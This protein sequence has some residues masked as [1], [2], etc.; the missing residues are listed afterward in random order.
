MVIAQHLL[1]GDFKIFEWI[2]LKCYHNDCMLE[3]DNYEIMITDEASFPCKIKSLVNDQLLTCCKD[4]FSLFQGVKNLKFNQY[5]CMLT[6][7]FPN[8]SP[9]GQIGKIDY[10]NTDRSVFNLKWST[11]EENSISYQQ[12]SIEKSHD[13]G[14]K[15]CKYIIIKKKSDEYP[16]DYT[17]AIPIGS[18]RSISKCSSFLQHYMGKTNVTSKSIESKISRALLKPQ[19]SVYG[20]HFETFC[21]DLS[22]ES[23]KQI[24]KSLTNSD[25]LYYASNYGRIKNQYGI[26][27]KIFRNSPSSK[28]N[29]TNLN[30]QH[31][32]IHKVIWLTFMGDIPENCE[33]LHDDMVP[34]NQDG[35]Y[36]NF[37][38]DLYIGT[39]S[40]NMKEYHDTKH[41]EV[42]IQESIFTPFKENIPSQ[43][44]LPKI[45][46]PKEF[47]DPVERLMHHLPRYIQ[48]I[49]P[50][51]KR[52]SKYV[53]SRLCPG[54]TTDYGSS[55]SKSISDRDKFMSIVPKY[56]ELMGVTL[57]ENQ[58]E[59]H[60]AD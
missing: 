13:K 37:L 38:E 11:V 3:F 7:A 47:T 33:I 58:V 5:R 14:G 16:N 44:S 35:T 54:L 18:F 1:Y 2:P 23:W 26:Y 51:E 19:L 45:A 29:L 59:L 4:Q 21:N 10:S 8:V 53:I 50:T 36:R 32:Y 41:E 60:K 30:Q 24:P 28:Y 34:L 17:K 57:L 31:I 9:N 40:D 52:G 42:I 43:D 20:F 39:H 49:K 55:G 12:L 56:N 25:K 46:D 6:S 15:H 48:Y 27:L 22:N